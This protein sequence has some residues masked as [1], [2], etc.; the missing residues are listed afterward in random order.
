[1]I[2]RNKF[3]RF[4]KGCN[5]WLGRKHSDKTK[6]KISETRKG[7]GL[8]EG[9]RNPNYDNHKLAGGK[10]PNWKGGPQIIQC[11]CCGTGFERS[12]K[13]IN[14]NKKRGHKNYCFTCKRAVAKTPRTILERKTAENKQFTQDMLKR[15]N[16]TCKICGLK[17]GVKYPDTD[18][19]GKY[20]CIG[21][22]VKVEVD[23]IMSWSRHLEL[24]QDSKNARTLCK[25]CHRV[26]G[27][28]PQWSK[29][30][31]SPINK[32]NCL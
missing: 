13:A 23:H 27:A 19:F 9:K 4:V 10:N 15:D 17:S 16:Y 14:L 28:N 7:L 18:F 22:K 1:M 26:Y 30:A 20:K 24:R 5:G 25:Q 8:A 21:K 2:K 31:T 12:L 3:G 29:W 32:E 6:R 11:A